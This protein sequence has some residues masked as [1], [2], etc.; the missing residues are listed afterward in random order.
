[1]KELI[2][3]QF[4]H[5]SNF[6]G[7]QYW[8][9]QRNGFTEEFNDEALFRSNKE[10]EPR[11]MIFDFKGSYDIALNGS[12][13]FQQGGGIF[14]R[15][16]WGQEPQLQLENVQRKE[17]NFSW[18]DNDSITY[19]ERSSNMLNKVNMDDQLNPFDSFFDGAKA[20][21]EFEKET[22]SIDEKL[23]YFAEECDELQGFQVFSDIFNGFSGFT[24][25]Y[26]Q[27]I[28]DDY[29]KKSIVV[30]GS[31]KPCESF[32]KKT[33]IYKEIN[34][35]FSMIDATKYNWTFIPLYPSNTSNNLKNYDSLS[36][37]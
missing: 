31:F 19:N 20:F 24:S 2:T 33:N 32:E 27:Q 12:Q 9:Q 15:D 6:I 36:L 3:L 10:K 11:C 13:D 26:L 1:M 22:D 8:S 21:E 5:Y 34:S 28:Q 25:A 16:L 23:R 4:G 14:N 30:F 17:S 29:N 37:R 35:A 7:S 18:S